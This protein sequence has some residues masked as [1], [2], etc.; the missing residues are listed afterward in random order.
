LPIPLRLIRQ[1]QLQTPTQAT[2]PS[3]LSAASGLILQ[4]ERIFVIADDELVLASFSLHSEE[5]GTWIRLW[6][7]QL[8]LL[9][10]ERKK[11]KPDFE[12]L[13][14]LPKSSFGVSKSLLAIPSGSTPQRSTGAW[15]HNGRIE[16]IDFANLYTHLR[17]LLP[18][19]N[20]EGCAIT[21]SQMKL[22]QRGNGSLG[23]NAI[24]DLNL[25][26]CAHEIKQK[27]SLSSLCFSSL[28]FFDLGHLR[29]IAL[30]FT[31]AA[32]D[33]QG[34]LWFL[35]VCEASNST[36]EDGVY[37]GAVLGCLNCENEMIFQ[38]ELDC[39]AKPEGLCLDMEKKLFYV[40]TDADNEREPAR[41]F[42]GHLPEINSN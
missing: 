19:L 7:Q 5:P 25:Q 12:S 17:N 31:D 2:R 10:A 15:I 18:E 42:E 16:K 23:Q 35:A 28:A 4:E 13:V 39:A 37:S 1:L 30:S 29:D 20:I 8:P 6:D 41:L 3:F 33:S 34:C 11:K 9:H 14:E 27:Q 36:Y 24:I 21:G 26:T 38:E 40:V 32:V 22:F